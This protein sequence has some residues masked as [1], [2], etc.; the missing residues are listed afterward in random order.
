MFSSSSLKV[1][2]YKKKRRRKREEKSE[3][4]K[5]RRQKEIRK[6]NE[7]KKKERNKESEKKE[8]NMG[9]NIFTMQ[10]PISTHQ[11]HSIPIMYISILPL[12]TISTIFYLSFSTIIIH[13]IRENNETSVVPFFV[14]NIQFVYMLI[15][16]FNKVIPLEIVS[17][18]FF[19]Y[20]IM[21]H[22]KIG[23][24]LAM[25]SLK[26]KEELRGILMHQVASK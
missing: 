16:A 9:K 20:L 4:K 15:F 6:E 10:I 2:I 24:P 14:Y 8:N 5:I 7:E 26:E 21:M 17:F 19:S 22:P 3:M 23:N 25:H 12:H 18:Y 1:T 13:I 11:Y